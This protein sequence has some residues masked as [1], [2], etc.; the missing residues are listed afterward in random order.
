[1][2]AAD[3]MVVNDILMSLTNNPEQSEKE[4]RS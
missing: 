2:I 3:L 4:T 1:L